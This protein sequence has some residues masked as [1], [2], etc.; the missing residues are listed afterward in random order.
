MC[1]SV[2]AKTNTTVPETED[3]GVHPVTPRFLTDGVPAVERSM[4]F[5]V[6][7]II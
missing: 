4:I 3:L 6:P 7:A 5:L 2:V 1:F